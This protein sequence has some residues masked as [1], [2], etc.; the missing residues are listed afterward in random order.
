VHQHGG[1]S[2]TLI[3][4]ARNEDRAFRES[5]ARGQ[6]RW[7]PIPERRDQ[8]GEIVDRFA[9]GE[10]PTL[11]AEGY[12]RAWNHGARQAENEV[13]ARVRQV[14]RA[15][16]E[17]AE[18]Q[19]KPTGPPT[20]DHEQAKVAAAVEA[21]LEARGVKSWIT[22]TTTTTITA[23]AV[24]QSHQEGRGRPRDKTRHLRTIRPR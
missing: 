1:R 23:R 22:T 8:R 16:G 21:I 2:L 11:S 9:I 3:P 5:L 4:R 7:R 13:A 10:G 6:S 19:R 17:L 24:E 14:D 15:L 20:R 12:R 18:L